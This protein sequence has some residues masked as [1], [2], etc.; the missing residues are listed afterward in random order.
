VEGQ[1]YV[2][3]VQAEHGGPVKIGFS[4]DPQKR[5]ID[6]QATSPYSLRIIGTIRRK[7]V[8]GGR[9]LE[10]MYHR[11]FALSRLHGEWFEPKGRFLRFL[12]NKKFVRLMEGEGDED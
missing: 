12:Q 10:A 1:S 11:T 8:E 9:W 7:T 6:L 2:Y 3:F 5:L 4:L